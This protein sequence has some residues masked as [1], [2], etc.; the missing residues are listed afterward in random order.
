MVEG[1]GDLMANTSLYAVGCLFL[2][3]WSSPF[4]FL[5]WA[6]SVLPLF[7]QCCPQDCGT[8]HSDEVCCTQCLEC[9]III[10][11]SRAWPWNPLL[12][13]HGPMA[14]VT[15]VT[16]GIPWRE[17]DFLIFKSQETLNPNTVEPGEPPSQWGQNWPSFGFITLILLCI[18][19]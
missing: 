4:A 15:G 16:E 6:F 7:L 13:W 2:N 19:Q 8:V 14:E 17:S 3:L 10:N 11:V 12:W 9:W 18:R 5:S 1:V